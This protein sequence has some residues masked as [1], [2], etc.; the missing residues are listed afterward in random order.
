[1]IGTAPFSPAQPTNSFSFHPKRLRHRQMKPP[2]PGK[3]NE[4]KGGQQP[5]RHHRRQFAG[6]NQQPQQQNIPTWAIQAR[7]S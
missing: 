6:V 4:E 7:E 1:M 5:H 3:E 2:R